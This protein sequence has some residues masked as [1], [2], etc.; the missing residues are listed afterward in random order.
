MAGYKTSLGYF[1]FIGKEL[2]PKPMIKK[3][4][5]DAEMFLM[6]HIYRTYLNFLNG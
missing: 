2:E 3:I 5:A 1:F 4:P 6:V